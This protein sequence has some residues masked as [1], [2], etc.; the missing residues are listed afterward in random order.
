MTKTDTYLNKAYV[1]QSYIT[2]K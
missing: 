2:L 1:I